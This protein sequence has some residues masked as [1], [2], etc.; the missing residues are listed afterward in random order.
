M[1]V[2]G[3][4]TLITSSTSVRGFNTRFSS[5]VRAGDVL[6]VAGDARPVQFIV[7]D[8]SLSLREAFTRDTGREEPFTVASSSVRAGEVVLSP[9]AAAAA[10]AAKRAAE[11]AAATG[12]STDRIAVKREGAAG[13]GAKSYTTVAVSG[14]ASMSREALLDL[15]A[16]ARGDRFC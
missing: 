9:A 3:I 4:G 5:Q 11:L 8:T 10:A 13:S 16:K 2:P 1:R 12:A 6:E 7:S 15:R 14:G